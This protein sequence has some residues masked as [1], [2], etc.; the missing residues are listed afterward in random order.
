MFIVALIVYPE[1]T[2]IFHFKVSA[3]QW[4]AGNLMS[5]KTP[6]CV[7]FDNTKKFKYFGFEAEDKYSDLATD[8]EHTNWY[9]F[10]R[11]KMMLFDKMVRR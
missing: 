1:C 2:S 4:N 6:T 3:Y 11:F 5:L 9:F 10:R 8:Q 7:L